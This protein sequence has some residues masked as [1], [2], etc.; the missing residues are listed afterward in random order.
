MGT[1]EVTNHRTKH[2]AVLTFKT[3]DMFHK[4]LHKVEGYIYDA[5]C[6]RPTVF[7]ICGFVDY[8][9][10]VGQNQDQEVEFL[11]STAANL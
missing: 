3:T 6:V 5:R 11:S 2:K 7:V 4:D 10:W 8:N 9:G 1:L